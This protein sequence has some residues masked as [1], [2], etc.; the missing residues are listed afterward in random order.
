MR[1]VRRYDFVGGSVS[2][3]VGFEVVKTQ[4]WPSPSLSLSPSPLLLPP[5]S[6]SPPPFPLAPSPPPPKFIF[7]LVFHP[8]NNTPYEDYQLRVFL[9]E[10]VQSERE[11]VI[12]ALCLRG[13]SSAA[14]SER[15]LASPGSSEGRAAWG[16]VPSAWPHF[17]RFPGYVRILSFKKLMF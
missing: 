3:G 1:R 11:G 17:Y 16:P 7:V 9:L 14:E 13:D 8:S 2:L 10:D 12:L 6:S 5:S 15:W 4:A